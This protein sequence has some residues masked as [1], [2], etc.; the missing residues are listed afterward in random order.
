VTR[1]QNDQLIHS[2]SWKQRVER[3]FNY[4]WIGVDNR[5]RHN[6]QFVS[7]E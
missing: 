4:A 2:L 7:R 3:R 5:R 1:A 6:V